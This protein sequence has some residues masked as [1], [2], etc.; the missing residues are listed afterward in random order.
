MKYTFIYLQ[1]QKNTKP[2][3]TTLVNN[4]EERRKW[5]NFEAQ[6]G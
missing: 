2:R 4:F 5:Q 1:I 3:Q 6:A